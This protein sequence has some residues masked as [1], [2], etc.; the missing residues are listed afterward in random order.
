MQIDKNEFP[1][2]HDLIVTPR[3]LI[4]PHPQIH[5]PK[6]D[7]PTWKACLW[8]VLL[9]FRKE[10][11][12]WQIP[13]YPSCYYVLEAYNFTD[14]SIFFFFFCKK[15]AFVAKIVPLFWRCH[16]SPV[17]FSNWSKFHVNVITGLRVI[18]IFVYEG[19]TRNL[20]I[21]YTPVWVL[22]NIWRLGWAR[23][24]KF[25]PNV[26]HERLLNSAKCQLQLSLFLSY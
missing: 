23:D 3:L 10:G 14:I 20:E 8:N 4:Y 17:K 7:C 15:S 25:G 12:G 22:P 2:W 16:V 1:L 19:L 9:Y 13:C 24:A 18:T 11:K 21:E 26:S 6:I 5:L